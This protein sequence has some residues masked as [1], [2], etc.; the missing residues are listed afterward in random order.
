VYG[1]RIYYAGGTLLAYT[2]VPCDYPSF[3]I[4]NGSYARDKT[5]GYWQGIPV[6]GSDLERW[7]HA[8]D[9]LTVLGELHKRAVFDQKR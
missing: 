1:P 3:V 4:L 5:R 2:T 7:I 6:D 8:D 9:R